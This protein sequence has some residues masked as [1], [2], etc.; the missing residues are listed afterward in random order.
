MND[1]TKWKKMESEAGGEAAELAT[2]DD[3]KI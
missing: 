3:G 1:V 2:H